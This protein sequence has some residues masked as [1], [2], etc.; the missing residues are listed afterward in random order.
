METTVA[1][2]PHV[3]WRGLTITIASLLAIGFATMLPEPG[4]S[5]KQ[6]F[7]LVCGSFG[8]VDAFLNV[9]LFVPLGIGLALSGVAGKR[10][11]LALCGLS[12]LIE[13]S[14]FLFIPGRDST[15]GDV[16]TNTIGG[17]LG[18]ALARYAWTWVRPSQRIAAILTLGWGITWLAI[19]LI[20][21]YAFALSLPDSRYY[22]QLARDIGTLSVFKGRVIS[23][24]ADDVAIPDQAFADSHAIRRAL[25]RGAP[26]VAMVVPAGPTR[27]IA[28]IVRVAD[29]EHRRIV[30][31]EQQQADLLFGIRTGAAVLRLRRPIFGL[32]H[33]FPSDDVGIGHSASD[34]VRLSGRYV[35]GEVTVSA[36]TASVTRQQRILLNASMAWTLVLPFSW[37]IE[38]TGVEFALSCVWTAFL[39]IPFGYWAARVAPGSRAAGIA[40]H[41]ILVLPPVAIGFLLVPNA[42]GLSAAPF[43]EWLCGLAG[44]LVGSGLATHVTDR[45]RSDQPRFSIPPQGESGSE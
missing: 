35:A 28:P 33:A 15:F 43:D 38:A 27:G 24:N 5:M 20:S 44:L 4:Q 30:V 45:N 40:R 11:L 13:T 6:H 7:C 22:G 12:M 41:W 36:Q 31:I 16:V 9:L 42:F 3:R 25:L 2:A 19:Q 23:A 18:F 17:A 37:L 21:N 1:L 8:G 34:V 14:Q 39:L 29:D 26:V 10:A 32:P